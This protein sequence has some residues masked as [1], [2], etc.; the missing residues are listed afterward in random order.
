MADRQ[1]YPI[2]DTE[3]GQLVQATKSLPTTESQ[4]IWTF[5]DD[6]IVSTTVVNLGTPRLSNNRATI[7]VEINSIRYTVDGTPPTA[8]F[9]HLANANDIIELESAHEVREFQAVRQG[10]VDATIMVSYGNVE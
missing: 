9:G 7:T 5:F 1:S 2:G 8:S 10:A 4:P 3:Y 6:I